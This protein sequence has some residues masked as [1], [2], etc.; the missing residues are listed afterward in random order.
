MDEQPL[1][2]A[3]IT[4]YKRPAKVVRRSLESILCQTYENIEIFIVNDF[5][6]DQT[7]AKDIEKLAEEYARRRT[8]HYLVVPKNGGACRARNLAL[9]KA[10]G[11]YFACLD[12]DDEWLPDKIRMQV[13]QAESCL[14]AAVVY[15]NAWIQYVEQNV[16]EL[17]FK[18]PQPTGMIFEEIIGRNLIGSCSFPLF[19]TAMLREVGGFRGDMPAL[20]DWELYLRLLKRYEAAYVREPVAVYYFYDGERISAHPG[21]RVKAFEMIHREF[22][23]ELREN[24]KSSSSFYLMGT[25]FYSLA[26]DQK[27]AWHYYVLGVRN[28]PWEIKRNIKDLCRM[29][30]RRFIRPSKV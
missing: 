1:V 7:L 16:R 8:I 12:D 4:T 9:T 3:V 29:A 22:R 2:S 21:N 26:G 17:L 30:G 10:K 6:E 23:E 28:S 25:Y 13:E 15:G 18:A 24:K 14:E 19:R 20:Q 27:R 5:P 11:T